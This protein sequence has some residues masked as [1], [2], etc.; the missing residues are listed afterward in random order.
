[1]KTLKWVSGE[2][3]LPGIGTVVEGQ[4]FTAPD[5]MAANFVDQGE[6]EFLPNTKT[7]T[8]ISLTKDEVES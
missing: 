5:V 3:V 6:A 8:K 4:V 7:V 2:R 1:M